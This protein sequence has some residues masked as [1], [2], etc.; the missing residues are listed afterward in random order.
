MIS[1]LSLRVREHLCNTLKRKFIDEMKSY[2]NAQQKYK[3][4]I[5]NKVKRLSVDMEDCNNMNIMKNSDDEEEENIDYEETQLYYPSGIKNKEM[6]QCIRYVAP[7]FEKKK[8]KNEDRIAV[9]C[10]KCRTKIK[11]D[12]KKNANGIKRHM[13]RKHEKLINEFC[14]KNLSL[15]GKNMQELRHYINFIPIRRRLIR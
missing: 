14:E 1:F 10:T 9:Y 4:N 6:W 5:K 12:A 3:N 15:S 11:Y 8:W 7:S 2:Q 13:E